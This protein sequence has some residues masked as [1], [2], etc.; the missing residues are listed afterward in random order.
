VTHEAPKRE[1]GRSDRAEDPERRAWSSYLWRFLAAA[2]L[3]VLFIVLARV[4]IHRGGGE[5]GPPLAPG[6]AEYFPPET[7]MAPTGDAERDPASG[8][9]RD[10]MRR[11]LAGILMAAAEEEGEFEHPGNQT[12][13]ERRQFLAE[14]FDLPHAY[15]ESAVPSEMVPEGGQVLAVFDHPAR[16]DTR[17]VLVRIREP[18]SEALSRFYEQYAAD[19]GWVRETETPEPAPASAAGRRG[20]DGGWLVAFRRGQHYRFVFARERRTEDET[21]AAI[22][23]TGYETRRLGGGRP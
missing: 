7:R 14:R 11:L 13:E 6:D 19:E 16:G 5:E 3:V 22:Y 17:M 9:S 4:I 21:L 23:D 12:P 1:N 10:T 2:A 20:E 15:P 18:L 8:R